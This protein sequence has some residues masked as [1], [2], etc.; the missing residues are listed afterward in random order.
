MSW[1][2]FINPISATS[3]SFTVPIPSISKVIN[4]KFSISSIFENWSP[5]LTKYSCLFSVIYPA[6]ME[7]FSA[8]NILLN[9]LWEIT[10]SNP[11]FL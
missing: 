1:E 5:T 6:G 3:L 11:A 4:S 10:P 9:E 7:K 2:L 8:A